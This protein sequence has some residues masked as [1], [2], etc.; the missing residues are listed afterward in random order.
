VVDGE[1]C[2]GSYSLEHGI[3]IEK[4]PEEI[5]IAEHEVGHFVFEMCELRKQWEERLGKDLAGQLEE[6]VM[7]KFLPLYRITRKQ[8]GFT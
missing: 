2:R 6:Q 3:E 4:G 7:D 8:N 1:T 5:E